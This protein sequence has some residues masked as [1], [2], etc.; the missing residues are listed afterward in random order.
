MIH[1]SPSRRSSD[2]EFYRNG[3][4]SRNCVQSERHST[5]MVFQRF[6]ETGI[7]APAMPSGIDALVHAI[8][9]P[10]YCL[11]LA[12]FHQ[13]LGRL[14]KTGDRLVAEP[15]DRLALIAGKLRSEE[16]TPELQ[17]LMRIS[18]AVICLI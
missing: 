15:D 4:L 7:P 8:E 1:A 2:L 3:S 9:R 18:S 16:H 13:F 10:Q 14:A 11:G 17:S 12:L 5:S 6:S